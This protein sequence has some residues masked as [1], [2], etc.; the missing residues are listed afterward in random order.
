MTEIVEEVKTSISKVRVTKNIAPV[1]ALYAET[2]FH[3]D[4]FSRLL[5][6]RTTSVIVAR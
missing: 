2:A 5:L 1:A 3:A 6:F 4:S